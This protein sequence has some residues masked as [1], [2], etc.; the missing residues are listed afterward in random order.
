MIR[1]RR[2]RRQR[3]CSAPTWAA[4]GTP[5]AVSFRRH[6]RYV[7][8]AG[9]GIDIHGVSVAPPPWQRGCRCYRGPASRAVGQRRFPAGHQDQQCGATSVTRQPGTHCGS[10]P[11]TPTCGEDPLAARPPYAPAVRPQHR[12]PSRLERVSPLPAPAAATRQ[13]PWRIPRPA[14]PAPTAHPAPGRLQ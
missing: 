8:E 10:A 14:A 2:S 5:T 13:P 1:S 12:S 6:T 4:T 9:S 7:P 11:P 3:P